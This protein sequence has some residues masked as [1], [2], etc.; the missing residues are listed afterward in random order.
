MNLFEFIDPAL[1]DVGCVAP[2]FF[3]KF[4]EPWPRLHISKFVYHDHAEHS[5]TT[6]I[7]L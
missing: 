1:Q 6:G 7:L 2:E 5:S 3:G 4:K